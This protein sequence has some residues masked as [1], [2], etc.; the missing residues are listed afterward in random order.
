VTDWKARAEREAA[1]LLGELPVIA[2]ESAAYSAL[3]KVVAVAWMQ[4]FNLGTHA[5]LGDAETSFDRLK[6]E[7]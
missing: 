5:T 7:L 3:Q 6:A 1:A 2:F 4:G